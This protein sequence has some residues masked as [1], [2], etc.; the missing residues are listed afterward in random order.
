MKG[1]PKAIGFVFKNAPGHHARNE[2]VNTV[3]DVE[4]IVNMDFFPALPD[5]VENRVEA[6]A[7]LA[8]W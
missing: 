7:N 5:R 3:D 4:R 1:S 6:K 8:D 2:Y